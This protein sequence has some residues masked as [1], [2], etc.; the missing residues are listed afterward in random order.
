[1]LEPFLKSCEASGKRWVEIAARV[2]KDVPIAITDDEDKRA[3][4]E[5][6]ASALPA[7]L[8]LLDGERTAE[9]V[10]RSCGAQRFLALATILDLLDAGIAEVKT[11]ETEAK[12]GEGDSEEEWDL[13]LG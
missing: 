12:T 10:A 5:D 9:D 4:S 11:A 7:V 8:F 3:K 13:G 6:V 2:P 1:D